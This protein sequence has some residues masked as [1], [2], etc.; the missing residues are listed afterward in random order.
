MASFI[1][2]RYIARN[3]LTNLLIAYAVI[4]CIAGLIDVVEMF[5]RTAD[6]PDLVMWSVLEMAGLRIVHLAEKLLPYSIMVGTMMSLM[7][8]MRSHELVVVRAAGVS[9]WRFLAPAVLI[10]FIL[11]VV[12]VIIL[13]PLSAASM[14]RY[15]RLE[16]RYLHNTEQL[17]SLSTSGLW[18]RH[19][20]AKGVEIGG[21]PIKNYIMQA[22]YI[23]QSD[24]TLKSIIIFLLDAQD[25]FLGRIDADYAYLQQGQWK[26]KEA[27]LSIPGRISQAESSFILPTELNIKQIQDSFADPSTLSFWELGSFIAT[28]EK[29]GFSALRH[30]LYWYSVLITPFTYAAMVLLAAIFSLRPPRRGK[31]MVMVTGAVVAGFVLH[32]M[33]GLFHAFGYAGNLSIEVSVIAPYL[34]ALMLSTVIL[35]HMEDG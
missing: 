22:K 23:D 17:L 19:S 6:K 32:F 16:A 11:G 4:V 31:M 34:I 10:S 13:N 35:L 18:L 1:L 30:K 2:Y 3:F 20:E 33:G 25:G 26:L 7:R 15:E 28:L 29:A 5:R 8:L 12:S 14:M 24:M 9:V 21:L 27:T